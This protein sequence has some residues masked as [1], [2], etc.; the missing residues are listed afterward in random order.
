MLSIVITTSA[1][2][3]WILLGI[4][5][6][7]M[8][9][10][11]AT[12][13]VAFMF[14]T[15]SAVYATKLLWYWPYD[16]YDIWTFDPEAYWFLSTV[17]GYFVW[18]LIVCTLYQKDIGRDMWLHAMMCLIGYKASVSGSFMMYQSIA[19]LLYEWSTPWLHIMRFARHYRWNLLVQLGSM[20]LFAVTFTLVRILWG[21]VFTLFHVFPVLYHG[22]DSEEWRCYYTAIG[23]SSALVLNFWWF[24]KIVRR[25]KKE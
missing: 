2:Y 7:F 11:M 19:F 16:T 6:T 18:D 12:K 24:R 22:W 17:V 5:R 10:S 9:P 4:F 3:C 1:L 20:G 13:A 23:V 15:Y 14:N 25:V 8:N 21:T